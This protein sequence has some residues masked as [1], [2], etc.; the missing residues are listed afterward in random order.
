[1]TRVVNTTCP[2]CS[3]QHLL[4]FLSSLVQKTS[5]YNKYKKYKYNKY[6]SN[7]VRSVF[8]G[9]VSLCLR[10]EEEWLNDIEGVV[11]FGPPI[12]PLQKQTC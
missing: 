3:Y 9:D 12:L 6:I 10:Q 7:S 1:M 11:C 2:L 8:T 4:A 5:M